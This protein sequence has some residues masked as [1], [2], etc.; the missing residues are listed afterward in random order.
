[1]LSTV[2]IKDIIIPTPTVSSGDSIKTF[3]EHCVAAGVPALPFRDRDG[4]IKG[5]VG[6]KQVM[7]RDCLPN[8]L[9]ELAGILHNDMD[10]TSN[11]MEKIH[12]LFHKPVD[13]YVDGFI[14]FISSD[15]ILIRTVALMEQH[16]TCFIFVADGDDKP[17]ADYKGVVTRLAVAKKMLQM[18]SMHK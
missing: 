16:D 18:E 6:L 13:Y 11:A 5:F 9:V 17:S 12:D 14:K 10:C 2:T 15:A 3:F 4:L 1:M 7:G 8:Y